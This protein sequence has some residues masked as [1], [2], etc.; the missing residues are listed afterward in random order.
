MVST[1]SNQSERGSNGRVVAELSPR[2]L[3]QASISSGIDGKLSKRFMPQRWYKKVREMRRDPT[4]GFV[5]DLYMAPILGAEWTVVSDS[6]EYQDGVQVVYDA[7]V[8]RK[9]KLLRDALRGL[10]DYGW[11]VFERVQDYDDDGNI[12]LRDLK[13]LLHDITDVLVDEYGQFVGA[14]NSSAT[15]RSPIE[16]ASDECVLLYRDAEG[17]NWYGEALMYRAE[18]VYDSWNECEDAA[19]RYDTKIAG[20]HWVIHYPIGTTSVDGLETDNFTVAK[21]M[22]LALESSGKI[23]VPNKV[24]QW[25]TDLNTLDPM[26]MAWR[27]EL[28]SAPGSA[29]ASFVGRQRYLDSLKARALGIPE[30]AALEGQFGTRAEAEA[31]ADFAISNIEMGHKAI[32]DQLND[33]ISNPLLELNLGPEYVDKVRLVALPLS[34]WKRAQMRQLYMAYF[35]SPAGQERELERLDWDAMREQLSLPVKSEDEI[36]DDDLLDEGGVQIDDF[37]P[38]G[39]TGTQDF[40]GGEFETGEDPAATFPDPTLVSEPSLTES[41]DL[42]NPA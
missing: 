42:A 22:L 35:N 29:E 26:K 24:A 34:D 33:Q 6:P 36:L 19:K 17:T 31:H 16:L 21:N 12:K 11:Q 37:T 15:L 14:Y 8:P 40:A 30:R 41:Q 39:G 10:I 1:G 38:T 20:A 13:P 3:E 9:D 25:V 7:L 27:I 4:L 32:I 28:L 23:I 2:S 5:R 18:K